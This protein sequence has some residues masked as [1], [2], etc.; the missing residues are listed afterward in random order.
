MGSLTRSIYRY[1]RGLVLVNTLGF[2]Q[3]VGVWIPVTQED[4]MAHSEILHDNPL[5]IAD[6]F[7]TWARHKIFKK[8]YNGYSINQLFIE[9]LHQNWP[10]PLAI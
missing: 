1:G 6:A 4:I 2:L 3:D 10:T 9:E 7:N 5:R 8:L